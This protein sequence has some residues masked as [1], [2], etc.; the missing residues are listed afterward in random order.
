MNLVPLDLCYPAANLR[1]TDLTATS[2]TLNWLVT[3][4]D[5]V[6]LQVATDEQF[7]EKSMLVNTVLVNAAGKYQ[8]NNLRAATNYFFRVQHFCSEQETADWTTSQFMTLYGVRFNEQFTEV[9]TYPVNWLRGN[10]LPEDV[11]AGQPMHYNDETVQAG[12][13]RTP[14]CAF[15]PNAIRTTTSSSLTNTVNHWLITPV[16]DLATADSKQQLML[17]FQMGLSGNGGAE[18]LPNTPGLG[19]KFFVA[20]SEDGGN[21]W[22]KENTT[23]WSDDTEDNAAFSYASIPLEGKMYNVD[24]SQYKGKQVKPAFLETM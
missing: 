15:A 1:V 24:L 4:N 16:I 5:S 8:M 10:T 23:W 17:S 2:A 21:T 14:S 19:D 22:K 3:G 20:V 18:Q 6:R 12:W 7:S 11:F 9:V 13:R